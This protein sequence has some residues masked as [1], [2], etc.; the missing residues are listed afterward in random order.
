MTS[1]PAAAGVRAG[2]AGAFELASAGAFE[3]AGAGAFAVAAVPAAVI[4]APEEATSHH[5]APKLSL[6]WPLVCPAAE[7]PTK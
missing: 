7:S 6:A 3:L 1:G 5:C 4:F 2:R